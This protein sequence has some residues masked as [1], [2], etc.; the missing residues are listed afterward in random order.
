MPYMFDSKT[1]EQKWIPDEQVEDLWKSGRFAFPKGTSV[2]VNFGGKY[3]LIDES[4]LAE[5][6][7]QGAS[8]DTAQQ[9]VL[10]NESAYF[11][12]QGGKAFALGMGRG[13]FGH[14]SDAAL[15]GM[16]ITDKR[17][18]DKIL[19]ANPLAAFGGQAVCLVGAGIASGG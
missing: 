15:V 10:R 3:G 1:G 14:L 5:A 4:Q 9:R 12:E 11:E 7:S 17:R 8:Y 16:G 13:G 19:D 18:I 6:F 2:H